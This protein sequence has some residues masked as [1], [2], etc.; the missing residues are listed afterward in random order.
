[1]YRPGCW[2]ARRTARAFV[3]GWR[4]RQSRHWGGGEGLMNE[5]KKWNKKKNKKTEANENENKSKEKNNK[6]KQETR[7]R[8]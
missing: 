1:M 7:R 3:L 8:R 6:K 2:G 4:P 5:E